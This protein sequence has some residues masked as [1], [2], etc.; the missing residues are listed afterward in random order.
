[1][2]KNETGHRGREWW[3]GFLFYLGTSGRT[4]LRR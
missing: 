3:R 2:K 4:S 1:M